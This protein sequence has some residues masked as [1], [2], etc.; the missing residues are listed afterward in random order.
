MFCPRP[1]QVLPA[2][3]HPTKCCYTHSYNN[4]LQPHVHPTHTTHVN[5][6]NIQNAHFFPQSQSFQ[7]VTSMSDIGPQPGLPPGPSVAGAYAPGPGMAPGMAPGMMP[8]MMGPGMMGPGTGVAGAYQPGPGMGPGTGV[9]GAYSGK[10]MG[11]GC[12]CR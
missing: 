4:V 1:T 3:V 7:N 8:G 2:I 10:H 11:K 6:T 9:A 12:G 5:H